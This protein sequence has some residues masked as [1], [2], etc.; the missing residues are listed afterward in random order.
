MQTRLI[1]NSSYQIGERALRVLSLESGVFRSIASDASSL[2]Q[3]ITIVLIGAVASA[4]GTLDDSGIGTFV[5]T[6]I[7][8]FFG[9]VVWSWLI[10]VLG[11]R[12]SVKLFPKTEIPEM[13]SV[14]KVIGFAQAPAILRVAGIASSLGPMIAILSLIWIIA[15][16]SVATNQLF[17]SQS[18]FRSSAVVIVS[19]V[20]YLLIVGGFTLLTAN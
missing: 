20:P 17:S 8:A 5:P 18:L 1:Q 4:V 15:A 11:S 16:M 2:A 6:I 10:Y 3:A 9:W 19:F 12:L 7:V 13:R 14:F